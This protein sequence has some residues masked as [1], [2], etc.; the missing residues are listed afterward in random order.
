MDA[1]TLKDLQAGSLEH[2]MLTTNGLAGSYDTKHDIVFHF[3]EPN[4][5]TGK[6]SV[7]PKKTEPRARTVYSSMILCSY[8]F[9]YTVC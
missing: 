2:S 3:A 8:K 1:K 6:L 4:S 7:R 9:A 5:P